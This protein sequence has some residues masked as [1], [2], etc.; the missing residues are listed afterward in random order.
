LYTH[1]NAKKIHLIEAERTKLFGYKIQK[2]HH[3][4]TH[5]MFLRDLVIAYATIKKLETSK[6]SGIPLG[7]ITI[8]QDEMESNWG[9]REEADHVILYGAPRLITKDECATLL[10]SSLNSSKR[11]KLSCSIL[12][13]ETADKQTFE[14]VDEKFEQIEGLEES[15][16]ILS[17]EQRLLAPIGKK[18]K[19]E[20]RILETQYQDRNP[21]KPKGSGGGKPKF[22]GI[23]CPYCIS[24]GYFKDPYK[25]AS[26]IG[27]KCFYNKK[28][29]GGT[30]KEGWTPKDRS[31]SGDNKKPTYDNKNNKGNNTNAKDRI[32]SAM[33]S[34]LA[35]LE[36][37][38]LTTESKKTKKSSKK[39]KS[40]SSKSSGEEETEDS[41][42]D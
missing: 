18:P 27:D 3:Y 36:K 24:K 8:N 34:R 2:G 25:V 6:K 29:P 16:E 5:K 12:D 32:N 23:L 37:A 35:L 11:F 22:D 39:A 13:G 40:V 41:D 19:I 20:E 15:I 4:A 14:A 42:S 33:A 21:D 10:R 9:L 31:I 7:D 38:Y 26:H 17:A 28:N 1:F 30:Y